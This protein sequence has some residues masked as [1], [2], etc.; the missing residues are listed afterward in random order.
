MF[1]SGGISILT[2]NVFLDKDRTFVI[3]NYNNTLRIN[4]YVRPQNNSKKKN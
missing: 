3:L 4:R 1:N 2:K